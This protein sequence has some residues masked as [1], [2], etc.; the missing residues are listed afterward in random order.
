MGIDDALAV[1]HLMPLVLAVSWLAPQD[2]FLPEPEQAGANT[3][4]VWEPGS[5]LVLSADVVALP[6][7]DGRCHALDDGDRCTIYD[8]RPLECALFPLGPRP[9]GEGRSAH[10][11]AVLSVAEFACD[12]GSDAPVL[13]NG[14]G[15]VANGDYR[16]ALGRIAAR[17]QS[18][19]NVM[20]ALIEF[21]TLPFLLDQV[22]KARQA[23]GQAVFFD[24]QIILRLSQRLERIDAT[25]AREL[26]RLQCAVLG[27]WAR[28]MNPNLDPPLAGF[29]RHS[30]PGLRVFKP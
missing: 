29:V 23:G 11:K 7:A 9:E 2:I 19:R 20:T 22:A 18:R 12:Q 1:A 6:R 13:I 24:F 27:E 17:G 15:E 28:H 25:R 26:A 10:I 8:R 16:A 4:G 21:A 3:G 30:L 14:R 5:G